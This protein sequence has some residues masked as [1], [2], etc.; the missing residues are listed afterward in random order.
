MISQTSDQIDPETQKTLNTPLAI[1]SG[2]DQKDEGFLNFVL[3]F[4][5][6][7]KIN[8]YKPDTLINH[9]IY[10]QLPVDKKGKA[11]I[12]A[13]NMLTAIREIKGL[14][15]A[16]FKETFQVQNLVQSIRHMKERLEIEG[17]DV[18]II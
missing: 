18:F 2:N 1:P 13:F 16:G 14:V 12:E 7:G 5:S 9:P 4:I 10:D 8:L 6:T 3:D 11:D 17:G 15:D